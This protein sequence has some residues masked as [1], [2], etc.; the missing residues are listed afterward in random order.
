LGR[1]HLGSPVRAGL[2]P[3]DT[4]FAARIAALEAAIRAPAKNCTGACPVISD[5]W[6]IAQNCRKSAARVVIF[7]PG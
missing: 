6:V 2:R 4:S 5:Q 7:R 3:Y 1:N